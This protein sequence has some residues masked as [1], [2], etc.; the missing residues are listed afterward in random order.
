MKT[1]IL[2]FVV[3][4]CFLGSLPAK[5][6]AINYTITFTGTG[7][8]TTIDRSD[9]RPELLKVKHLTLHSTRR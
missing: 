8:S 7:A 5:T 9:A 3:A 2:Q 1:K 4:F 6:V